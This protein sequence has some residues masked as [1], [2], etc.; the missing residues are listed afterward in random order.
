MATAIAGLGLSPAG[1]VDLSSFQPWPRQR[2]RELV[3]PLDPG[4]GPAAPLLAALRQVR[5]ATD[6]NDP[7]LVFPVDSQYLAFLDR[8]VSGRLTVFAP[9]FFDRGIEIER[10][11]DAIRKSMPRVVLLAPAVDGSDPAR[12]SPFHH[13][14]AQSH[15]YALRFIEENYT[16]KL[17]ECDSC[18]VLMRPDSTA[19]SQ[20]VSGANRR[21]R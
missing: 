1:R 18:V 7:I 17:H 4:T 9:G 14:S 3:H 21:L 15:A 16:R 6:R 8:P 10:N 2:L 5:A 13:H 12:P 19:A 20:P 11:L